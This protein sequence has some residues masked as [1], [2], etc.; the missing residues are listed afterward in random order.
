[1][2]GRIRDEDV[3]L[4]KERAD[5]AEV[6][7]EH[8]TLRNAGG[9][10]LKGLCPFHD[11]KTPSF[12]V[13]PSVGAYHCFGC[14]K[15]GDVI[16]FLM[17]IDHLSFAESVERLASRVGI[18]LRYEDGG[19][20]ATARQ[21]GQQTRLVAAHAAAAEFYAE[22]LAG[23]EAGAGRQ[24]LSERGF[25]RGA[26]E[27]FG[28]GY[29]P[30]DWD[31]L[32][33]HLR[34][35][36]FTDKELLL[37]GLAKEG[38][39]G[40]IDRFRGRLVWPIR[41]VSGDVIGFGARRLSD[42]DNGPKYLNTP[43]TPIYKKSSV[44]Y[45]VDLAKKDIARRMQAVVVE[46]YT[47]V[48]ACHLSG[49]ETAVATCGTAFGAE[50]IKILRRLLMDQNE[51]RG[52]VV[53][54]FDGDSAGQQAA[55]K[56]FEDDQ[57]FVTQTF[58]AVEP[59]GMDPCDLRVQKGP[60]AVR[61]LVARRV[62]LFEF[63]IRSSVAS[64]DL[65]TAEGRTAATRAGM[66]V[67]REIR[68]VALRSD[69]A[70]Q[71]AGWVGLADPNELVAAARGSVRDIGRQR[72]RQAPSAPSRRAEPEVPAVDRTPVLD[73]HDPALAVER[74]VLKMSLQAPQHLAEVFDALSPG[75]FTAAPYLAVHA[76]ILAAGGAGSAAPGPAWM[77]AVQ[78]KAADD[79]VRRLVAELAVEPIRTEEQALPRYAAEIVARLEELATGRRIAEVKSRLQRL[80]PVEEIDDYNRMF[81]QLVALEQHR[82]HLRER[83]IGTL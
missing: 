2:A 34:A 76:A 67:V 30:D 11:E 75:T 28:V 25:D 35:R 74:E 40:S 78:D 9:G 38:R 70:R 77:A 68:D 24:F 23:P 36:G 52:E 50:H 58:V 16:S 46:G 21:P 69:Y 27:R 54:T 26:A 73:P 61:D 42:D 18:Q 5:L 14:Q 12:S 65:D 15:S 39:R 1:V 81:G 19:G 29:A 47:D 33:R 6:I 56:A 44:L 7:G 8:V 59:S 83:A 17:E 20:G 48:M 72:Q 53:F 10:N 71:L 80:N 41:N 51:F 55:L 22:Q 32:T 64:Y 3:V 31:R 37:G 62:P 82:R 60:E 43:E 63:K 49:V 79:G 57:R 13:R 45:G 66:E 4:V